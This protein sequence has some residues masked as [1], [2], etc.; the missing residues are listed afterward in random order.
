MPKGLA[1]VRRRRISRST[2]LRLILCVA[3]ALTTLIAP[4]ESGLLPGPLDHLAAESPA[5]AQ[6]LSIVDG[7][8]SDCEDGWQVPHAAED[9]CVFVGPAC[10]NS[11]FDTSRLMQPSDEF[12]EFCEETISPIVG[13]PISE[14]NYSECTGEPD[15]PPWDALPGDP[16]TYSNTYI[17]FAVIVD[18]GT[19]SCRMLQLGG[20]E[21]G[22]R[23]S[24]DTCR[25]TARR[26]WT[27]D[28]GQIHLNEFNRCYAV[29]SD[30]AIPN[31][32]CGAGAPN[33]VAM[34]CEDYV[35]ND[36]IEPPTDVG[37]GFYG[38]G[39]SW[40]MTASDNDYWCK[41]KE[42]YLKSVCHSA[43]SPDSE[44]GQSTA[45]CLKRASGTGG[46]DGIA[47]AMLCRSEQAY[48]L[49]QARPLLAADNPDA[50]AVQR[51]AQIA[52]DVRQQGCEPCQALPFEPIP[53]HCPEDRLAD[54][55]YVSFQRR[56]LSGT[57]YQLFEHERDIAIGATACAHLDSYDE[58]EMTEGCRN[59]DPGCD[60][61]PPGNP[62]WSST[63]FS[64]VAVVNSSVIVRMQ[65]VAVDLRPLPRFRFPGD[66]LEDELDWSLVREA[67]A[68][69]P[70][71]DTLVRSA[72]LPDTGDSYNEVWRFGN[73]A[74]KCVVDGLPA[75]R[76]VIEELW[77]D[78]PDDETAIREL[79]GTDSLGW[80]DAI[81]D[82]NEKRR[83]TRARGLPLYWPD[84]ATQED[85]Q[86][87]DD[88]L[89]TK[90]DCNVEIDKAVWCR[91]NPQRSGYFRLK[92]AGAWH[93]DARGGRGW[94]SANALRGLRNTVRNF[95]EDDRSKL[96]DTLAQLGCGQGQPVDPSCVWTPA[97]LG[98]NPELD[99]IL[100]TGPDPGDVL[101]R[102][103]DYL[104]QL[105][106]DHHRSGSLDL[107]VVHI[108]SR[109][110]PPITA[111][112]TETQEFGIQVHAVSVRTV[113]PPR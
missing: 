59:A 31:Q 61:P 89:R 69:F 98:L 70:G 34:S 87:R 16:P 27:C 74:L 32:L 37:C 95:D 7:T 3:W 15:D 111:K 21:I 20:C 48:Y 80:W 40:Q 83:R 13:D 36:F 63:H 94:I 29:P 109:Y 35:G 1:P 68:L 103:S 41:F 50:A 12:P 18:A 57:Q 88:A 56:Q 25:A 100:P 10:P 102:D 77:P 97:V 78:K 22:S 43:S 14:A 93:L 55:V 8:P 6:S 96:R 24:L 62:V 71:T 76:V 42:S 84:P 51:L 107:R 82:E 30:T 101:A 72:Y 4:L 5:H 26:S 2:H 65:D 47:L 92:V 60:S 44:C 99:D 79:F 54:P 39:S 113:T 105:V 112:Y 11:P 73:I 17:E 64:G 67:K 49:A 104:Y 23:V 53:D 33:L 90:V 85:R 106:G 91:W 110:G 19:E 46:C 81:S 28:P 75:F 38:A 108:E 86:A 52:D 45:M 58:Q 9:L 66:Y